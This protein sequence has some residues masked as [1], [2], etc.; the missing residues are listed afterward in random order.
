MLTAASP[1]A[2]EAHAI[3]RPIVVMGVAGCGK[4]SVGMRLAE[5]LGLPYQEGDDLHPQ[6]NIAKMSMG[7]P[8]NDEDRWPWLDRIGE[9]LADHATSGI[10]LTCSSLKKTYRDR[11]R[12]AVGG[13]LAF[14]FLDGS[15]ALLTQRM[16]SREGH[17]MPTSLLESQLATLERPDAEDGVVVVNIDNTPE[18]IAALAILGLNRLATT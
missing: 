1:S 10:I 15:K 14:V 7:T 13:N 4:S 5:V 18:M 16:G 3:R 12:A 6:A 2:F 8:L 9:I 11:L 17:F